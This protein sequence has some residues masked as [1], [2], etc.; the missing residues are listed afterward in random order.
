[1]E[2]IV[3]RNNTGKGVY[4]ITY[5]SGLI[6]VGSF[7][8]CEDHVIGE[9]YFGSSV[10]AFNLKLRYKGRS[11]KVYWYN[12][13]K[14][15]KFEVWYTGDN[16]QEIEQR[17]IRKCWHVY[18]CHPAAKHRNPSLSIYR[19]G[20]VIN[21]QSNDCSHLHTS[22]VRKKAVANTDYNAIASKRVNKQ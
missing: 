19:P 7:T 10:V 1:M 4:R 2:L 17:F 12:K 11:E 8:N 9:S 3:K 13:S 20:R 18:G 22:E 6:Y 16:N 14:I 21:C 15:R 5:V